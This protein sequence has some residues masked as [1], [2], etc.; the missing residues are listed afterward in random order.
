M[1]SNVQNCMSCK[2]AGTKVTRI[3]PGKEKAGVSCFPLQELM[4]KG[5]LIIREVRA[6]RTL[7]YV[8]WQIFSPHLNSLTQTIKEKL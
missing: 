6:T 2:K 1:L 5:S 8:K 3:E 4:V 7:L